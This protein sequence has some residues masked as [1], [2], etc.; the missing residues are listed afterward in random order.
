VELREAPGRFRHL[1]DAPEIVF[2]A[3]HM[4]GEDPRKP[5]IS[6]DT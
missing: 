4:D 1:P 2:T 6:E 5:L 3:L